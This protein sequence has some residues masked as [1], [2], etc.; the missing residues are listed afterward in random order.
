MDKILKSPG[1][2]PRVTVDLTTYQ[3][4]NAGGYGKDGQDNGQSTHG[5]EGRQSCENEP[6]GQQQETNVFSD[7]HENLLSLY[8]KPVTI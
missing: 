3:N 6:D 1:Q 4:E 8:L 5:N 7:I 2:V